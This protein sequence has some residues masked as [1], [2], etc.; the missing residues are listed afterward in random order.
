M[1][2][3][4]GAGILEWFAAGD[5]VVVVVAINDVLDRLVGNLLDLINIGRYR[6]RPSIADRVG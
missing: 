1:R 4:L 5:V 6:L 2:D 3:E